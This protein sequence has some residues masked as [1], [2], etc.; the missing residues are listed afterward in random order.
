MRDV[1]TI[2]H[3]IEN[4][5]NDINESARWEDGLCAGVLRIRN[6]LVRYH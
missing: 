1:L 5:L 6:P 3:E 2:L 4:G